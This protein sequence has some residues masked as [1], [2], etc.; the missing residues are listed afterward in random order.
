[1]RWPGQE[2]LQPG[3]ILGTGIYYDGDV[4]TSNFELWV[5][6]TDRD[7]FTDTKVILV[8]VSGGGGECEANNNQ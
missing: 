4:E 1:M 8:T 3:L 7:A 5:T 2:G 6:I